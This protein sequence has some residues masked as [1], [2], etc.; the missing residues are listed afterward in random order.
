MAFC[1]KV[2]QCEF[3]QFV[4]PFGATRTP[5]ISDNVSCKP[6]DTSCLL[7]KIA[8]ECTTGHAELRECNQFEV[9]INDLVD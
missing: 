9:Q 5:S 8:N 3:D 7:G 4:V 1:G 6:V 2:C